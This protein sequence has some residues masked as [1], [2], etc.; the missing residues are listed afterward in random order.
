M[1]TACQHEPQVVG[2]TENLGPVRE[3]QLGW[4]AGEPPEPVQRLDETKELPPRDL[5][6]GSVTLST[7]EEGSVGSSPASPWAVESPLRE[8]PEKRRRLLAGGPQKP[9][10]PLQ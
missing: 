10:R 7:G 5:A 3:A 8:L 9:R 2:R 6:E 1:S 4:R